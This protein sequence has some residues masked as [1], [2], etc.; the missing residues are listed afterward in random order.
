MGF[1]ESTPAPCCVPLSPTDP[2]GGNKP[3]P[4][5]SWSLLSKS[6]VEE[7]DNIGGTG[8]VLIGGFGLVL[9]EKEGL[10]FG[11]LPKSVPSILS[12]S[13][14]DDPVGTF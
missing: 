2:I 12:P 10:G 6:D 9:S 8:R 5:P 14:P 7:P 4:E 1:V 3:V 13:P 11:L